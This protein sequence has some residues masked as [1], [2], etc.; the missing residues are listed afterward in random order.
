MLN[1]AY[2]KA[3]VYLFGKLNKA[4]AKIG[5]VDKYIAFLN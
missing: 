3:T 1:V 4:F 2:K 5:R